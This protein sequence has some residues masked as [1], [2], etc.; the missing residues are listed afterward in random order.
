M[1]GGWR[2][3]RLAWALRHSELDAVLAMNDGDEVLFVKR[4]GRLARKVTFKRDGVECVRCGRWLSPGEGHG[5]TGAE[6]TK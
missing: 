6:G 3:I 1:A 4:E 2:G 5:C